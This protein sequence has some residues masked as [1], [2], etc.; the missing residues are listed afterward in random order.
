MATDT[1]L[2][3]G[4]P[5]NSADGSWY[6]SGDYLWYGCLASTSDSKSARLDNYNNYGDDGRE[7]TSWAALSGVPTYCTINSVTMYI[8]AGRSGTQAGTMKYGINLSGGTMSWSSNI[9]PGS[10]GTTWYGTSFSRPGGG[11]WARS[12]LGNIRCR[13]YGNGDAVNVREIF[14]DCLL[15][16][17]NWDYISL[18]SLTT[19]DATSVTSSS[20]TI[21]GSYNANGDGDTEWRMVYGTSSGSYDSPSWTAASGT[22]SITAPTR[23]LSSLSAGTTYY[24]RLEARNTANT[25]QYG[26]EK[27]FTTAVGIKGSRMMMAG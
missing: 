8:Y 18:T 13:F 10:A 20:A 5:G 25:A 24:Y 14:V 1:D 21:S 16:R 11:S 7:F 9:T 26:A 17:I 15:V 23:N 22:G 2:Y 4:S 19:N 27:T 6:R 3:C 12:D